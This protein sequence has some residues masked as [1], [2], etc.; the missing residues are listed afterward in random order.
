MWPP[1]QNQT[2]NKTQLSVQC[3]N[4]FHISTLMSSTSHNG[5]SGGLFCGMLGRGLECLQLWLNVYQRQ[6]QL[7]VSYHLH[8]LKNWSEASHGLKEEVEGSRGTCLVS[9]TAIS[10]RG[11]PTEAEWH[12]AH[13][14]VV[15]GG[16]KC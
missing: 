1:N 12:S 5:G 7:N 13:L 8:L 16:Q 3:I 14:E 6:Q 2:T 4:C 10:E 9:V 11:C 15:L